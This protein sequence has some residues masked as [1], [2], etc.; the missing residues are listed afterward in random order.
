MKKIKLLLLSA[1]ISF[2]SVASDIAGAENKEDVRSEL[3][4]GHFVYASGGVSLVVTELKF[5]YPHSGNPST[6]G[7]VHLGYEW[8]SKVGFMYD[9]YFTSF[10]SAV[11]TS[12]ARS[13]TEMKESWSLHYFAPQ[14]AGRILL[15]SEKWVLN[16]SLGIGL[17]MSCEKVKE[18]GKVRGE[19]YD[20]GL[21]TNLSFGAEYKVASKLGITFGLS[22][23]EASLDQ[24][25]GGEHEDSNL[26]RVNFD[27][28]LKYHF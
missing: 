23:I 17:F 18:K 27:L 22:L 7:N 13:R 19:N 2:P 14:L 1:F 26:V 11:P 16:Y 8:I 28:G 3:N 5:E 25:Y 20:Y 12:W 15:R 10:T 6:G 24:N 4:T 9:G 21:G